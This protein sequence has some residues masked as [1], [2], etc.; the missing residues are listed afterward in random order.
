M[1]LLN[2]IQAYLIAQGIATEGGGG[3]IPPWPCYL[4]YFPD[5]TDQMMAVF[6]TGGMPPDTMNREYERVTFQF[7]VRGKR[8]DY[9]TVRAQWQ[10]GFNVLQD[11]QPTSDYALIQAMH[12]GPM[13]FN[14]DRGRPNFISN[15]RVV[16]TTP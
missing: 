8:L 14:D 16:R 13:T 5:D 15:F 12:Y 7:R 11:S 4:G 1:S 10:A 9:P 2:D 6:E 3:P